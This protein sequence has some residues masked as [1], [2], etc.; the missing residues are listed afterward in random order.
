MVDRHGLDSNK[1]TAEAAEV[2]AIIGN[3]TAAKISEAI[4]P[5]CS[6]K[7]LPGCLTTDRAGG[8]GPRIS[9]GAWQHFMALEKNVAA[10]ACTR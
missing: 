4:C 5:S 6:Q 2:R 7:A 10:A 1:H 8:D 9:I 3:H